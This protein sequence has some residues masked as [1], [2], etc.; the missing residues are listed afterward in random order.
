MSYK[1]CHECS[2]LIQVEPCFECGKALCVYCLKVHY[3]KWKAMAVHESANAERA[4]INCKSKLDSL[5]PLFNKNQSEI[6]QAQ[7]RIR[8][9]YETQLD[10]LNQEKDSLNKILT[11][12][13]SEK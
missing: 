9:A 10:K 4:L 3:D 7:E 2:Q 1:Q 13:I 8:L 11:D 12:L 6:L 5:E